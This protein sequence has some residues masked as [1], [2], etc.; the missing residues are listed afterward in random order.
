MKIKFKLYDKKS[1]VLLAFI[2]IAFYISF[3]GAYESHLGFS[4][5]LCPLV[6]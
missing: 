1:I 4:F 5:S 3:V 2:I 6:P